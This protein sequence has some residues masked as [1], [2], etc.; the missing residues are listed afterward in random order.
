MN[1][2]TLMQAGIEGLKSIK[3]LP[4]SGNI[5]MGTLFGVG[6]AADIMIGDL[7][8]KNGVNKE[9]KEKTEL[10]AQPQKQADSTKVEAKE[11]EFKY[12]PPKVGAP[13]IA[14]SDTIF[15]TGTNQPANIM[16]YDKDGKLRHQTN[17]AK[18][19]KLESF[20]TGLDKNNYIE[21]DNKGEFIVEVTSDKNNKILEERFAECTITYNP[22]GTSSLR[23][24]DNSGVSVYDKN[25]RLIKEK[26][27]NADGT[28]KHTIIPK[29]NKEGDMV[30]RDTIP[31]K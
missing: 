22:D 27:Y 6:A 18:D 2:K 24:N 3:N 21:Y 31:N 9:V 12:V 23:G 30:R 10:V 16:Y 17:Y 1:I 14:S 13:G 29:Y 20:S 7:F 11:P 4:P 5:V 19:G 8:E 26:E 28:L 25:A 15:Y